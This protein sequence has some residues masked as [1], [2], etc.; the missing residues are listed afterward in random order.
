MR[1]IEVKLLLMFIMLILIH[2]V[3]LKQKRRGMMTCMTTYVAQYV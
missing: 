1:V 2:I 3:Q